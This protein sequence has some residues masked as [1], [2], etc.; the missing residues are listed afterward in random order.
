MLL[1]SR[2]RHLSLKEELNGGPLSLRD[3]DR[4]RVQSSGLHRVRNRLLPG[5]RLSA[6]VHELLLELRGG[7]A[8]AA[9]GA[10][11]GGDRQTGLSARPMIEIDTDTYCRWCA[12][13]LAPAL[14]A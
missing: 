10:A 14:P 9:V 4:V 1:V 6:R 13:G 12:P 2:V 11:D 7:P 3:R 8:R 5:L